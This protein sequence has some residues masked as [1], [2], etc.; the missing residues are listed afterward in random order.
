MNPNTGYNAKSNKSETWGSFEIA[1]KRALNRNLGGVGFVFSKDDPY[2][3]I[4]LDKCISDDGEVEKGATEI[5][6]ELNSYTELSP[7]RKGYHIICHRVEGARIA[8][9]CTIPIVSSP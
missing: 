2:V 6:A 8:S 9:R 4:D 1:V 3:G 5:I 7:S